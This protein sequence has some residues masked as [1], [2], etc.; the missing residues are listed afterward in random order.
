[1]SGEVRDAQSCKDKAFLPR[2]YYEYQPLAHKEIRLITLYPGPAQDEIKCSLSHHDLL[3]HPT[4]EALSY[5][6]GVS[7]GLQT[8]TLNGL[9]FRITPNLEAALRHL[10]HEFSGA[11]VLWV[12]A[13]CIN[14]CDVDERNTQVQIMSSIFSSAKRV[15]GWLGVESEDSDLAMSLVNNINQGC[16]LDFGTA[17][18]RHWAALR[19]LWARPY[20]A[21]VWIVQELASALDRDKFWG[22]GDFSRADIGCGSSWLPLSVFLNAWGYL[23]RY[24]IHDFVRGDGEYLPVRNLVQILADHAQRRLSLGRAIGLCYTANATDVRDHMYALLNIS[25]EQV[26]KALNPDYGKSPAYVCGLF[27]HHIIQKEKNL[28]ILAFD[29]SDS[30]DQIPSWVPNFIGTNRMADIQWRPFRHNFRASGRD[31]SST[32]IL[33]H[34]LCSEDFSTLT[35]EGHVI[36]TITTVDGPFADINTLLYCGGNILTHLLSKAALARKRGK[37]KTA[38]EMRPREMRPRE[39]R[40]REMRPREMR[41]REMRPREMRPKEM[42]PKEM[43][44]KEKR[45]KEMKPKEMGAKEMRAKE[46]RAKEIRAKEIRAK[47]I[48]AKELISETLNS[49]TLNSKA[50]EIGWLKTKAFLPGW[51]TFLLGH[52][53]ESKV[54]VSK[55]K[56][57]PLF[58][59]LFELLEDQASLPLLNRDELQV[60]DRKSSLESAYFQR[61]IKELP[62]EL[63]G[64]AL[65]SSELWEEV[66][67]RIARLELS[68]EQSLQNRCFF[69]TTYGYLGVGPRCTRPGNLVTI[70]RGGNMCFILED[71]GQ[72]YRLLGEA[73]TDGLM[74]GKL[75][76]SLGETGTRM[77]SLQ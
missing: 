2:T 19:R 51:I 34:A 8:I 43:R 57:S 14:Q 28:E 52:L 64:E 44:A 61:Q 36:D 54:P 15:L 45:P 42:R 17:T 30:Q 29:H 53:R 76:T 21:R 75:M 33:S 24:L 69:T 16:G 35:L 48:R 27:T 40:P 56:I 46:M 25:S 50:F 67:D 38:K 39:M 49:E 22:W 59:S 77:F 1:M 73:Y 32:A 41:P 4:Y 18:E 65:L 10:R 31:G 23:D 7:T 60:S 66:K 12:D 72:H 6:W 62:R 47:E 74:D 70:L 9:P 37:E 71:Q 3:S 5:T 58:W 13:L 20:W 68:L 11:R 63:R 55:Y 26:P